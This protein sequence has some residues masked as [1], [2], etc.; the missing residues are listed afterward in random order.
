MTTPI[1][2][3]LPESSDS[4]T[5]PADASPGKIAPAPAILVDSS[6]SDQD[7]ESHQKAFDGT[8]RW[9]G[10]EL[11]PWSFGRESLFY[12]LRNAV[13]APDIDHALADRD[14][15]L[16]DAARVLWLCSHQHAEFRHLRGSPSLMQEAIEDWADVK[17]PRGKRAAATLLALQIFDDSAVNIAIPSETN[18]DSGN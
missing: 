16:A 2:T 12:Q 13:G 17:I 4:P 11:L 18:A 10:E 8:Y 5:L 9:Q 1:N 7:D 14:A 3:V 6:D 15:F